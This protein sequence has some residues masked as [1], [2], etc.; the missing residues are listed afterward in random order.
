MIRPD[1]NP[2]GPFDF[3][4]TYDEAS[5]RRRT[6][7]ELMQ[8]GY[9]DAYRHFIEPIVAV[10]DGRRH[11]T[12]SVVRPRAARTRLIAALIA[13]GVLWNGA[14][15][16]LGAWGPEGHRVVAM[17]AADRLS[18]AARQAVAWLLNGQTLADIAS[19][20][21]DYAADHRETARWHY[22]DLPLNAT[23]YIASRD[24]RPSRADGVGD[25]VVERTRNEIARL[26]NTT[27]SR[28]DRA[29][30]LKFVVHFVADVHQPFHAIGVSAGGNGIRVT[31]F[32]SPTAAARV[33][34]CGP[35]RCT[36]CGTRRCSCTNTE[37]IDRR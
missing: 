34:C 18:P 3:R 7:A 27:L 32:G 13:V 4:G 29:L 33:R 5:D 2:I 31:A 11:M 1:H 6:L 14:G 26:G 17:A 9:A 30:A 25:C 8:Q 16:E 21:D 36:A 24:C 22:V 15:V 19:W 28:T 37:P 10:G 23:S 35:A 20:A 12:E